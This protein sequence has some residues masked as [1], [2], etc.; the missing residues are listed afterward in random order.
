MATLKI[1][2]SFEFDEDKDLKNNFYERARKNTQHHVHNCSLNEEY[3]D[4]I[5]KSKARSAIKECDVVVVLIGQDTHNA[6]GS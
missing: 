2:V 1:F 4:E 5:W 6:P 3:S